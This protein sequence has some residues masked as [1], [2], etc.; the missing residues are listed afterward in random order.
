VG[1]GKLEQ[2]FN[3]FEKVVFTCQSP[4]SGTLE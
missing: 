1:V 2:E 4:P 3:V